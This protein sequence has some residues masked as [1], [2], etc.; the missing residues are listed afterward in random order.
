[1]GHKAYVIVAALALVGCGEF[2]AEG[3]ARRLVAD[4][5]KD[6]A[7][8]QFRGIASESVPEGGVTTVYV[9]GEVNGRNS[10]GAY[11]G[12]QRF[13]VDLTRERVWFDPTA[14]ASDYERLAFEARYRLA[15]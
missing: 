5:L 6:P 12:Y 11:S 3:E 14:E 7:S 8:A 10:Y 9:C 2:G 4:Q 13:V 1:M 15:C